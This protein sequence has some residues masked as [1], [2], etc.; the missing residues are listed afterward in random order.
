M[1][2]LP[3]RFLGLNY[4]RGQQGELIVD[5]QHYVGSME[6]PDLKQLVGKVKHDVL[7]PELQSTFRSLTSK[8]NALAHTL[9]PDIMYVA[10]E[11]VI[12]YLG[13][14]EDWILAGVVDASHRTS[15]SL[16]PVEGHVVMLINKNTRA[17]S[18]I[19]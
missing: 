13:E 12:P 1:E 16:F 19:L 6:I 11:I 2:D 18:T 17:A 9:R 14:P 3:A 15:G 8:V 5:C 10:N 4:R 7:S